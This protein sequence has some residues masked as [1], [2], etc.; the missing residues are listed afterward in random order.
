MTDMVNKLAGK[1]ALVTGA[2]SGLGSDIAKELAAAGADAVFVAGRDR[3]AGQVIVDAIG[4]S[5]FLMVL[6][7][8][9]D[10]ALDRCVEHIVAQS[11]RIDILINC[12]AIYEDAGLAS[13]RAQWHSTLNVNLVSAAVLTCKVAPHMPPGGAVVNLS[14]I[15]GKFGAAGRAAYPASKAALLQITK[16]FAVEL[17]PAGIRVVSVSPAWTWSPML[18]KVSRGSIDVA[19]RVGGALHPLGRVGRGEEIA[20]AVVFAVSPDASWITGTDL[21]V[22]GGFA[23]LGPDQGMSA[24]RWFDKLSQPST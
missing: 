13:T 5:A 15:G 6:D 16:N 9:D 12:A 4:P 10:D 14:S 19:D 17:A 24:S 8:T 18:A 20:K 7:I 2:T 21:A 23:C 3:A 11:G 1:V 22:D